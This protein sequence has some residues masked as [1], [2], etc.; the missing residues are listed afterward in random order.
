MPKSGPP[1]LIPFDH[2]EP[3]AADYSPPSF[4]VAACFGDAIREWADQPDAC[5]TR[6]RGG[7]AQCPQLS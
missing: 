5:A 6:P 3:V 1:Q 7:I 4:E 2:G